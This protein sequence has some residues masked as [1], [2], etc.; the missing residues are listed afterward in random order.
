MTCGRAH[1]LLRREAEGALG[2]AEAG[3]L[4][5]HHEGCE[6]CRRAAE[7]LRASLAMLAPPADGDTGI[8]WEGQ[9]RRILARAFAPEIGEPR[10]RLVSIAAWRDRRTGWLSR[11]R[12]ARSMRLAAAVAA[13]AFGVAVLFGLVEVLRPHPPVRAARPGGAAL[14]ERAARMLAAVAAT[15]DRQR[16]IAALEK[17]REIL[18]ALELPV[19]CG[20]NG[21]D[22]QAERAAARALLQEAPWLDGALAAASESGR[23][24]GV[25]GDLRT[26]MIDLLSLNDCAASGEVER[27]RASI[28]RSSLIGRIDVVL[29]ELRQTA[30]A[31]GGTV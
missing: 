17:G 30:Q 22:L 11:P 20:E 3:L 28:G 23:G 5:A 15:T 1:A 9:T 12:A 16:A 29:A 19:A 25:W 14:E 6:P 26:E 7:N 13:A 2:R 31:G 10:G 8:D 27:L 24:A 18:S 21:V 4:Q